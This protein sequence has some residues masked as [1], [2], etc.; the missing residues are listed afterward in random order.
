MEGGEEEEL[1]LERGMKLAEIDLTAD[2]PI[3]T[4]TCDSGGVIPLQVSSASRVS[5]TLLARFDCS[6]AH[7]TG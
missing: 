7:V 1:Q 2:E 6:L 3:E 5:A 4:V